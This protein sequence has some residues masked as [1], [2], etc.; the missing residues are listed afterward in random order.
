MKLQERP[1]RSFSDAAE[2]MRASAGYFS[3]P[4]FAQLRWTCVGDQRNEDM[5]LFCRKLLRRLDGMEM[6]FYPEVGLMNVKT[7]QQRYVTG[8]DPWKPMENPYLDGVAIKL[9]HCLRDELPPRC[10]ALVAEVG[11]DVARLAA[12]PVVWGG[13]QPGQSPGYWQLFDTGDPALVADKRTYGV[14]RG[15]LI[16]YDLS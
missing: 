10:W 2:Y 8:V 6:P 7:A 14:K 1:V 12:I 5:R 11:F 16:E 9:R 15:G 4:A 3:S 13:F